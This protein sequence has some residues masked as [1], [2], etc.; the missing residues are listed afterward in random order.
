MSNTLYLTN[1]DSAVGLMRAAGIN[2]NI[3][4]WQD[5]L[6]EGPVLPQL[7]L[8]EQSESRARFLDQVGYGDYHTVIDGLRERD[9]ALRN[10][11]NYDRVELWF[12]HDLYDQL[13][14]IQ[15]LDW[16]ARKNNID[17][18]L[19]LVCTDR[20]L[21]ECQPDDIAMLA[22][23]R[24]PIDD[25]MLSQVRQAF[26]AFTSRDP[27]ALEALLDENLTSLPYLHGAIIRLLEEL[28][29]TESGLT[30]IEKTVLQL[31]ARG[32]CRP[33][34][35]FAMYQLT[36]ERRH[37]GDLSFWRILMG[38]AGKPH[39][40]DEANPS[41]GLIQFNF[42]MPVSPPFTADQMVSITQS[43]RE[44]L[45]GKQN[46]LDERNFDYWL[47]GTHLCDNNIWCIDSLTGKVCRH[48]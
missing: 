44:V 39:L 6:H 30:R 8:T 27:K 12:E 22:A 5:I 16:F 29:S 18:P 35:L 20:Y 40:I 15:I 34:K 24:V 13:Q 28:P 10:H 32:E 41:G 23:Y 36:E 14:I 31:L 9:D 17:T 26:A 3:I 43:G 7:S 42:D 33:G 45:A 46:F 38:L 21:G 1:G 11:A 19:F 25:V 48:R 2:G 4:P 37:L 47:G